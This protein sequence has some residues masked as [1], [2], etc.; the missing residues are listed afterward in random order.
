MIRGV[1]GRISP[2][3][4]MCVSAC[5]CELGSARRRRLLALRKQARIQR[6]QSQQSRWRVV[7]RAIEANVIA[8][9]GPFEA[10][11]QQ[12]FREAERRTAERS[13]W[14]QEPSS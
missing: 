6:Q 4:R 13:L 3:R 7:G 10:F 2:C 9:A 14:F 12:L 1:C 5:Y 8:H 11:Q